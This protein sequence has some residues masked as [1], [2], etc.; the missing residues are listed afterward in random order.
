[1]LAIFNGLS[2]SGFDQ[3]SQDLTKSVMNI[4]GGVI[5]LPPWSHHWVGM[6]PALVPVDRLVL[7]R[8]MGI[9]GGASPGAR[10]GPVGEKMMTLIP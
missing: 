4:G 9:M 8:R 7:F 10:V 5:P 3:L 1:M 2:Q 6:V